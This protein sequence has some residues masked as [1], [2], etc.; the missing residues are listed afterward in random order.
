MKQ[1]A[2]SS[3]LILAF[4]TN[5]AA[6][7]VSPCSLTLKETSK[8]RFSVQL[9]LP[10]LQGRVPKARPILPDVCVL[11]GPA[12]IQGDGNKV[13]YA[14]AMQCSPDALI[15][16]TIGVQGLL[17][18][19]LDVLVT[20]ELLDGR[21]YVATLRPTQPYYVVPPSP[22]TVH[23]ALDIG[24]A[25]LRHA[26]RRPELALLLLLGCFSGTGLRH[27]FASAGAFSIALA[28]G[29]WLKSNQWLEASSML[30]TTLVA[31]LGVASSLRI[32]RG[33][34]ST[35]GARRW[36]SVLLLALIGVLYGHVGLPAEL[37][38]ARSEQFFALFWSAA[39]T[40]AAMSLLILAS[41]ELHAAVTESGRK[42]EGRIA[43]GIVFGAGVI[44]CAIGL[45][46]AT[47]LPIDAG[48][49]AA[50]PLLA[51]AAF[52]VWCGG[53]PSPMRWF[54]AILVGC[55]MTLGMTLGLQGISLPEPTL[56]VYGSMVLLGLLV[57]G[58][59][60]LP[61]WAAPILV[62]VCPLYH[63]SHTA[64]EIRASVPLPI[65]HAAALVV[66]LAFVFLMA[67]GDEQ[68]PLEGF[69]V[70]FFG[71]MIA[72][73]ALSWRLAEY[74]QWARDEITID[75]A[76]GMVRIP[77][78]S[79]VLLLVALV[80]WPRK[81]RFQP[82]SISTGVPLHLG[83]VFLSLFMVSVADVRMK[84][85]FH[86]PRPPTASEVRPILTRLLTDTYLAFNL[87]DENAAFD[88]LARNVSVD[89]VPEVYLDSRRRLTAGTRQGA[90]VTVKDV[91]VVSAQAPVATDSADGTFTSAC[92]WVVTARVK[93]WRH[94]HDRQN[95]YLGR[96]GIRV[97]NDRWKI[98]Q[99][100]LLSEEREIVARR[101]P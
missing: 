96:V 65:A 18:T 26:L 59:Y 80:V 71:M 52:G 79:M 29:Q 39:G 82:K 54:L 60:R 91:N 17:G 16:E 86:T 23:L 34:I 50:V 6:D 31:A 87:T 93:H 70:Q 45:Y 9:T 51:V 27:L 76:M 55:S 56:V 43:R 40:M 48:V 12:D 3:F 11:E 69:A 13:V 97:E 95:G 20:M 25:S 22:T 8:S 19:F 74:W 38:L 32:L 83:L 53:Q 81:R 63:G 75:S 90:E 28:F 49:M 67:Y 84:I 41:V 4:T 78:L 62:V 72:L 42:V 10:I 64:G 57:M 21:K 98:S 85:P 58:G 47:A 33:E 2:V 37:V 1:L 92:Q 88:E 68:A 101:R 73:V 89:L 30:P 66:L 15:G 61:D 100:E 5:A 44:A 77:V 46:H 36:R 94:I 24:G 35:S 14:W 7:L 99:I